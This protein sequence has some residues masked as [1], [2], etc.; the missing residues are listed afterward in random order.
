MEFFHELVLMIEALLPA[1]KASILL[2]SEDA[3]HLLT[4]LPNLDR[5][6][7]APPPWRR[8]R[9]RR[10]LRNGCLCGEQVIVSDVF[11]RPALEEYAP[12]L[13]PL[14]PPFCWSTPI[15]SRERNVLERFALYAQE[16]GTPSEQQRN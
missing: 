12:L 4:A 16:V 2:L 9:L 3:G 11:R 15:L 13:R 10:L 8:D 6:I 5:P 14:R 1:I 7:I